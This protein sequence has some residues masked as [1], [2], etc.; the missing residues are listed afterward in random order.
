MDNPFRISDEDTQEIS[1]GA[2]SEIQQVVI[3]PVETP[4]ELSFLDSFVFSRED[5]IAL[6]NAVGLTGDFSRD[7]LNKAT[8]IANYFSINA[9]KLIEAVK[10]EQLNASL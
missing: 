2:G 10:Q 6:I 7:N 3:P 1:V 4:I 9:R 5:L 8:Y